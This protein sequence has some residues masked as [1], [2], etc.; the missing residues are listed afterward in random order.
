MLSDPTS[1]RKTTMRCPLLTV[2]FAILCLSG[3]ALAADAALWTD[4]VEATS[5]GREPIVPDFSFAGYRYSEQP[6]PDVQGATFDVTDYGVPMTTATTMVR[7]RP[8]STPPRRRA[9]ASCSSRP[10]ASSS[11]PMTM[12]TM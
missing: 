2:P 4:F 5:E 3:P 12:S 11:A 6:I 10:D 1:S 8:P 7:F 9:A